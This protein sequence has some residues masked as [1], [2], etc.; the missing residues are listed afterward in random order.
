MKTKVWVGGVLFAVAA[1][2]TGCLDIIG[3]TE[4]TLDSAGGGGTGGSGGTTGTGGAGGVTG[5]TG[6]AGG[7]PVCAPGDTQPCYDGA[8][9]TENVGVCKGGTQTCDA[10]GK[11]FGECVG[12]VIPSAEQ[13]SKLGNEACTGALGCSDPVFLAHFGDAGNQG[14]QGIAVEPGTGNLY[15]VGD[16]ESAMQVGADPLI[17]Q[18]AADAFVAKLGATGEPLWGRSFGNAGLQYGRSVGAAPDGS[19]LFLVTPVGTADFGGG[20][21]PYTAAVVKLDKDG[22]F[23]WNMGCTPEQNNGTVTVRDLAVDAQGNVVV[24]GTFSGTVDCGTGPLSTLFGYDNVL[25]AKYSSA[26]VV[27]WV[28]K[29]GGVGADSEG[30]SVAV[31]SSGNVFL[32]G[33]F[34]GS[35]NFSANAMFELKDLGTGGEGFVAKLNGSGGYMWSVPMGDGGADYQTVDSVAVDSLGAPVVGG[36]FAGSMAL[37]G[38]T[39]TATGLND[40]FVIKFAAAGGYSW[41]KSFGALSADSQFWLGSVNVAVDFQDN[42]LIAGDFEKSLDFGGQALTAAGNGATDSYFAK[43]TSAGAHVWSKQVGSAQSHSLLDAAAGKNG[44]MLAVGSFVESL[45]V[46]LGPVSA[47]GEDVFVVGFAP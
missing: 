5:G 43:L 14:A 44:E 32:G 23:A 8:A 6:G 20:P 16:F 41:G 25:V 36:Q 21:V 39:F 4:R 19:V 13:C 17:S 3:Y 9:G 26:G 18:G 2:A 15:V 10:D 46:G 7:A 35:I 37:F 45:D 30:H 27:Q 22:N 29:F 11:G 34:H 42:V 24:V 33:S 12:E 40:L 47:S 1:C 38:D 31:D 28:K